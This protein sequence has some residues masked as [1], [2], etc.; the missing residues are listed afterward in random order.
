[1]R[2][3]KTLKFIYNVKLGKR[4]NHINADKIAIKKK[5]VIVYRNNTIILCTNLDLLEDHLRERIDS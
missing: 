1:M 4:F 5:E 3:D 2:D